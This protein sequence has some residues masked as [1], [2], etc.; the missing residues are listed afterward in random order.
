MEWMR[1]PHTL[2]HAP[3]MGGGKKVFFPFSNDEKI[4]D[5]E[6]GLDTGERE[7]DG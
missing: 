7:K 4:D 1:G 5:D 2:T 3:K 6:D